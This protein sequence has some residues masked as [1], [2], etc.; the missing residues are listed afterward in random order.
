MRRAAILALAVVAVVAVVSGCRSEAE[1]FSLRLSWDQLGNQSCPVGD[2]GV[3]TCST[4][5]ISCDAHVLI[6]IMPLEGAVPYY[7]QCYALSG[8]DDACAL[9]ELEIEPS[10]PI[11]NEMVRVQVA[12]WADDQ[13]VDG[14][15]PDAALFDEAGEPQTG[16]AAP[17][18]VPALG[19]EIYFPVGDRRVAE[20]PLACPRANL[21]DTLACRANAP[22]VEATVSYLRSRTIVPIEETGSLLVHFGAATPNGDGGWRLNTNELD[23]LRAMGAVVV[24]Q[25]R[26]LHPRPELGCV[27]VQILDPATAGSATCQ[28]ISVD[29]DPI[30]AAGYVVDQIQI[31]DALRALGMTRLPPDGLVMG[32][33]VDHRNVRVGGAT[34]TVAPAAQIAYPDESSNGT[35]QATTSSTGVFLSTDASLGSRWH[36]S[37]PNGVGDDGTA[38]GGVIAGHVSVVIVR[39]NPPIGGK[40]VP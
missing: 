6:R 3:A 8:V 11:P 25:A 33:V 16:V 2:D 35:G 4:I 10:Q 7:S 20:V 21:L 26:L 30:K 36:G 32:V 15:C 24:W 18:V 1:T 19:G 40:Q 37:V 28:D 14:A 9:A 38:T 29:A 27:R 17:A 23:P 39:L 22:T 12:V 5:P 13:L 31:D 34:V